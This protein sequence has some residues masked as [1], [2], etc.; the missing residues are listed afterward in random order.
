MI[1]MARS[2][3]ESADEFFCCISS[4]DTFWSRLRLVIRVVCMWEYE[5]CSMGFDF[6][7]ESI[8]ST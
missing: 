7:Y 2:E 5:S 3:N 4:L 1:L 6:H 8:V